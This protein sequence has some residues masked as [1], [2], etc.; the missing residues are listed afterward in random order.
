MRPPNFVHA[1]TASDASMASYALDVPDSSDATLLRGEALV[2]ALV[3]L[4]A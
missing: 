2:L 4:S 1:A 3:R